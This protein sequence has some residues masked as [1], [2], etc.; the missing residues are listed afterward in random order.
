MKKII[1][2]ISLLLVIILPIIYITSNSEVTV[3]DASKDFKENVS[4]CY[5][6]F[7]IAYRDG[8]NDGIG[9]IKGITDSL[10]YLK[11]DLQVDCIWITPIHPSKSYHKYDVINYR[12]IDQ[13]FGTLDDYKELIK[14]AHD[15]DI[16]ILM[17]FV[18][19]HTSTDHEWFKGWKAKDEK[20]LDYYSWVSKEDYEA[21]KNKS[22]WHKY[23]DRYYFGSFW[24]QMPELNF[25]N[26]K[27]RDEIYDIAKYWLKLGVDGFRIDAAKHVYDKREHPELD[28]LQKNIDFFIEFNDVV[29]RKNKNAFIIGEIWTSVDVSKRYLEG[30][31]SVFNFDFGED[32]VDALNQMNTTQLN[33]NV[34]KVYDSF[35]SIKEDA[36]ISNFVTNHDQNR[37]LNQLYNSKEKMIQAAANY[38]MQPGISWIYYGEEIGMTGVKP[39]ERIREPFKW[40]EEGQPN[41]KWT[42]TIANKSTSL[43]EQRNDE[44]S[45]FEIY[46]QLVDIRQ[47]SDVIKTGDIKVV[48]FGKKIFAFKRTLGEEEIFVISN[49][50]D[51]AF[52]IKTDL[53]AY[54]VM[55][56]NNNVT[57]E[58][59]KL[60]L[61]GN[62]TIIVGSKH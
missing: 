22:G 51:E 62:T 31:D 24:D 20:Y 14:E 29:K 41:S 50:S 17:D 48:E 38:L 35:Y 5:E 57:I 11:D 21:L 46:K 52:P 6:V 4:L 54:E 8:N 9:D 23:D 42:P 39:D 19:N 55:F 18:I 13:A 43:E 59:G 60:T 36:I 32:L 3:R 56:S 27:V 2:A 45:Y 28:T 1:I 30:M 61:P 34:T 58:V 15:R 47:N 53:S 33:K 12:E 25:E 44:D 26:E 16:R 10:D 37:A 40:V 7:P 49:F